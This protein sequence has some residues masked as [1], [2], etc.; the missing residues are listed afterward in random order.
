[1]RLANGEL[2]RLSQQ[3][4]DFL[5]IAA[6]NLR[7]PLGAVTMLLDNMRG[8]LRERRPKSS[9]TGWTGA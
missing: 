3:R 5:N 2:V 8:G 6:H 1:M 7:G 4:K 9:G